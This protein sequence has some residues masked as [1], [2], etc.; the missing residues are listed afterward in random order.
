M[1]NIIWKTAKINGRNLKYWSDD[2]GLSWYWIGA[3]K[4]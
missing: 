1:Q 3:R 2:A 4:P